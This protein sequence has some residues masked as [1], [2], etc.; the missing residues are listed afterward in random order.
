MVNHVPA[1]HIEEDKRP[2][3]IANRLR[4]YQ[5]YQNGAVSN[6]LTGGRRGGRRERLLGIATMN[7]LMC[8]IGG[9]LYLL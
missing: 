7:L 2:K 3:R 6:Q 1:D 5:N 9:A 4:S 8:D